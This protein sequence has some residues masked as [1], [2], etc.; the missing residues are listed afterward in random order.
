MCLEA[1]CDAEGR[2]QSDLAGAHVL[3]YGC[4][5]GI[6]GMAAI[7]LGAARADGVDIDPVAL[8]MRVA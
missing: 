2:A 3:D 7:R 4:G 6:L 1:L 5:S 8:E